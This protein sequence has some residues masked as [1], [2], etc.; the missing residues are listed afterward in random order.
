[1]KLTTIEVALVVDPEVDYCKH[2]IIMHLMHT[3]FYDKMP[4]CATK[5]MYIPTLKSESWILSDYENERGELPVGIKY[6]LT[7]TPA[8]RRRRTIKAWKK[9]RTTWVNWM[10]GE[11]WYF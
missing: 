5:S 3:A 10:R 4:A 6:T 1:M 2:Q 9:F 7:M 8:P 11:S